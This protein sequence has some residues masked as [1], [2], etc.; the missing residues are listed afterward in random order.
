MKCHLLNSDEPITAGKDRL[1]LCG[2]KVS[3]AEFVWLWDN[4]ML[5]SAHL[6]SLRFCRK[7]VEHLAPIINPGRYLYGLID[8]E[9]A[10]H[11]E[12]PEM[13]MPDLPQSD[14]LRKPLG[15]AR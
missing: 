9:S 4:R 13:P 6:D 2:Q 11:G 15:R 5:G 14:F 3:K 12:Q 1:A 8:G 10:K 7:C